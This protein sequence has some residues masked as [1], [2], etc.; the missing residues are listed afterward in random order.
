MRVAIYMRVGTQKQFESISEM[1]QKMSVNMTCNML[2]S[3]REALVRSCSMNEMLRKLYTEKNL[4][5]PKNK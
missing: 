4:M 2:G 1:E 5:K 3:S